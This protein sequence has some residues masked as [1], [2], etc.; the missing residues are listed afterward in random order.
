MSPRGLC[1]RLG[2]RPL[3]LPGGGQNFKGKLGHWGHQRGLWALVSSAFL[4]SL[5]RCQG[6]SSCPPPEPC[7]DVPPWHRPKERSADH[8]PRPPECEPQQNKSPASLKEWILCHP[9]HSCEPS[10]SRGPWSAIA[11]TW[12]TLKHYVSIA[13]WNKSLMCWGICKNQLKRVPSRKRDWGRKE[14]RGTQ[15]E[16]E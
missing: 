1:G 15:L 11:L 12:G 16:R 3:V 8:P 5:S 2:P 9:I 4:C 6:A 7:L 10:S 13:F 14:G